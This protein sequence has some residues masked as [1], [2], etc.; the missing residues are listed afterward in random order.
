MLDIQIDSTEIARIAQ[1]MRLIP[2][3]VKQVQRYALMKAQQVMKTTAVNETVTK[4]YVKAAELR[5]SITTSRKN[6][7]LRLQVRGQRRTIAAYMMSPIRKP[8]HGR[9]YL[10]GAVRRGMGLKPLGRDTFLMPSRGKHP[11][12]PMRRLSRERLPIEPII[13]PAYPQLVGNEQTVE[14]I[15]QNTSEA[16]TSEFRRQALRVLGVLR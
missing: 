6:G 13:A 3:A 8:K 16:I 15:R 7:E 4:Y 11:Y 2:G 1:T 9:Y 10:Y 14:S 5:K 12:L